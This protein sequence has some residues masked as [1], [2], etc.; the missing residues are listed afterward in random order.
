MHDV[1]GRL[2]AM[3]LEERLY[4]LRALSAH[5]AAGGLFEELCTL[6]GD[7]GFRHEKLA[8]RGSVAELCSDLQR[9]F[10]AALDKGEMTRAGRFGFLY[11]GYREGRMA[12]PDPDVL[13]DR[14]LDVALPEI[15]LLYPRPRL[16]LLVLLA[17][18]EAE[19]G[20]ANARDELIAEAESLRDVAMTGPDA[21]FLGHCVAR[22]LESGGRRAPELLRS[23]LPSAAIATTQAVRIAP[24]LALPDRLLL[25]GAAVAWLQETTDLVTQL[26]SRETLAEFGAVCA[27]VASLPAGQDRDRLVRQLEEVSERAQTMTEAA[28]DSRS[29]LDAAMW[30]AI[31]MTQDLMGG[32]TAALQ[33]PKIKRRAILGST[34]ARADPSSPVARTLLEETVEACGPDAFAA[35]GEVARCLLDV[36][37]PL[38]TELLLRLLERVAGNPKALA[39]VLEPLAAPGDRPEH[40]PVILRARSLVFSLP[41]GKAVTSSLYRHLALAEIAAGLAGR[42]RSYARVCRMPF[43]QLELL[44]SNPLHRPTPQSFDLVCGSLELVARTGERDPAWVAARLRRLENRIRRMPGDRRKEIERFLDLCGRLGS[45]EG[46]LAG[47]AL[48]AESEDPEERVTALVAV[49][50]RSSGLTGEI[51]RRI[52]RAILAAVRELAGEDLRCRLAGRWLD[53]AGEADAETETVVR[54]LVETI[55]RPELAAEVAAALAGWLA[56]LGRVGEAEEWWWRAALHDQESLSRPALLESAIEAAGHSPREADWHALLN[57]LRGPDVVSSCRIAELAA[58]ACE[59]TERLA[60]IER[61]VAGFVTSI[62][63]EQNLVRA[64]LALARAWA[65]LGEPGRAVA[66]AA[67]ALAGFERFAWDSRVDFSGLIE[68]LEF[69]QDDRRGRALLLR[70]VPLAIRHSDAGST[71]CIKLARRFSRLRDDAFARRSLGLLLA[72]VLDHIPNSR[73]THVQV[74]AEIA[75]G[76]A[77]RGHVASARH[78]AGWVPCPRDDDGDALVAPDARWQGLLALA[79][80]YTEIHAADPSPVDAATAWGL[81]EEAHPSLGEDVSLN[82]RPVARV[83]L[84]QIGRRLEQTGAETWREEAEAATRFHA[85]HERLG[86]DRF[87]G[88][89]E[90]ARAWADFGE[91]TPALAAARQIPEAKARDTLLAELAALAWER[92]PDDLHACWREIA[93]TEGRRSAAREIAHRAFPPDLDLPPARSPRAAEVWFRPERRQRFA[94]LG[95]LLALALGLAAAAGVY[96]GLWLAWPTVRQGLAGPSRSLWILG[97]VAAM[98]VALV[99]TRNAVRELHKQQTPKWRTAFLLLPLGPLLW[100]AR[101]L[102]QVH[103]SLP[104]ARAWAA[105]LLERT[106]HS[107][108]TGPVPVRQPSAAQLTCHLHLLR[109]SVDDSESFDALYAAWLRWTGARIRPED[110]LWLP[111]APDAPPEPMQRLLRRDESD[112]WWRIRTPVARAAAS[113]GKWLTVGGLFLLVLRERLALSLRLRRERRL[114][115]H[116]E[117][118]SRA[119][120]KRALPLLEKLLVL[121]PGHFGYWNDY[122]NAKARLGEISAAVKAY[123]EALDLARGDPREFQVWYNLGYSMWQTRCYD[124]SLEAFERVLAL[125]PHDD[126]YARQAAKGRQYCLDTLG[127]G[128][129]A[130]NDRSDGDPQGAGGAPSPV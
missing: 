95:W 62:R 57:T 32:R 74:V 118:Y 33:D 56:A 121:N 75:A 13:L 64:H 6:L 21:A 35:N 12:S 47:V 54:D 42:A 28:G 79:N 67:T 50:E 87:L 110:P 122:A 39:D 14:N 10:H 22:L 126:F 100:A 78:L 130:K 90:M 68:T 88:W 7:A 114:A 3:P 91:F 115:Q 20:R 5:L 83:E 82:Q 19:A 107:A 113:T 27:A 9:T 77:R 26:D 106:L 17:L 105:A 71:R 43:D 128:A 46:L 108:G 66:R 31:L 120:D 76:L 96:L 1:V 97:L 30:I 80:A 127:V 72:S 11:A 86:G 48:A 89:R 29:V 98:G 111:K 55:S 49:L 36:P 123:R 4:A 65:R 44:L 38:S 52:R 101:S 93:T 119:E 51:R 41:A 23:A 102:D 37:P 59:D 63:W 99:Q 81:L 69:L 60:Q 103:R 18:R 15:R 34:L 94:I 8:V 53:T 85:E 92:S 58:D 16:R 117:K 40:E 70:L 45:D 2:H 116:A 124:E 109:E 112:R 84:W 104:A 129:A 61:R 25:L 73:W 24:R 125:A